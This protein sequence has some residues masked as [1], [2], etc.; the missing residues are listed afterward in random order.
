M[1][2]AYKCIQGSID[3]AKKH[4][5]NGDYTYADLGKVKANLQALNDN[6]SYVLD[7][8]DARNFIRVV[9]RMRL[10]RGGSK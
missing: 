6:Y 8:D 3:L 9:N 7:N 4:I 5:E 1:M 10:K 2:D